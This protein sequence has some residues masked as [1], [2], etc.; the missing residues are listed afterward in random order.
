[1]ADPNTGTYLAEAPESLHKHRWNIFFDT[2]EDRRESVFFLPIKRA[3]QEKGQ[4]GSEEMF[5]I[6]GIAL[7]KVDSD[8]F[9]RCGQADIM[10]TKDETKFSGL[11][12]STVQI[13]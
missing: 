3:N 13:I 7:H 11:L 12:D 4:P 2:E 6:K 5:L 9:R 10:V 8:L 1:M